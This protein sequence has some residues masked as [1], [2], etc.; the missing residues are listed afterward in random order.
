VDD[1]AGNKLKQVQFRSHQSSNHIRNLLLFAPPTK[2]K[3]MESKQ[4]EGNGEK[5]I[6]A[7]I[8]VILREMMSFPSLFL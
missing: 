2:A 1:S 7:K 5:E 6:M 4:G 8:I 3:V